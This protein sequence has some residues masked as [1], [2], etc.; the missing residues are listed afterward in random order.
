MVLNTISLEY[1]SVV[2]HHATRNSLSCKIC[3]FV[4]FLFVYLQGLLEI[5]SFSFYDTY[6]LIPYLCAS[7]FYN[8]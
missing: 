1:Y 3:V 2:L 5:Q 4:K 8:S 6:T 7:N